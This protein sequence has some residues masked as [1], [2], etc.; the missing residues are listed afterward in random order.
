MAGACP[1]ELAAAVAAAGGMG[2]AGVVNDTPEAIADWAARFRALAGTAPFQLNLWIP[3]PPA[4]DDVGL[5][6]AYLDS[7]GGTPAPAGGPGPSFSDQL[8]A[9]LAA[10]PA[11]VSTI[12]GLFTAEQVAA[13]HGA[14]CA[15]FA[16]VTTRTEAIAAERAG[17]D[18]VVVQGMEAGGHRG[19]TDPADAEAVS[20]GLLALVPWVADAVGVPVVA[21][22]AIG[23]GR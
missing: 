5:Q 23:D 22:G 9:V 1:P 12:M 15:W 8:V 2:A 21:A 3:D 19:T 7:L 11:V 6:T 18:A 17:A 20:V 14:G 4:D 13:V 10:R 16:T